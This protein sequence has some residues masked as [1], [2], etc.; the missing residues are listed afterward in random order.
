MNIEPRNENDTREGYRVLV[1]TVSGV[2]IGLCLIEALLLSVGISHSLFSQ[3]VIDQERSAIVL[4]LSALLY[5]VVAAWRGKFIWFLA[6]QF[7]MRRILVVMVG[8]SV[9]LA[10]TT[11]FFRFAQSVR[12]ARQTVVDDLDHVAIRDA[13]LTFL[14]EHAGRSNEK[15]AKSDIPAIIAETAP[16]YVRIENGVLR[17]EYGG[18]SGR[19]GFVIVPDGNPYSN[20]RKLLDGLYFYDN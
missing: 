10:L 5:F 11:P 9:F 18:E 16:T 3:S 19:F 1:R 6:P 14:Q 7:G 4:V 12:S 20:G 13:G 8:I 2:V 15:V 17:I